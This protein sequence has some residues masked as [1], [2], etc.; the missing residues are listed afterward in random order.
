MNK[1]L[2][3]IDNIKRV[4]LNFKII[5]SNFNDL[6]FE[7]KKK[8][9]PNINLLINEFNK[10]YLKYDKSDN[11]KIK[12]QLLSYKIAKYFESE[13]YYSVAFEYYLIGIKYYY[14]KSFLSLAIYF[15]CISYNKITLELIDMFNFLIEKI[16]KLNYYQELTELKKETINLLNQIENNNMKKYSEILNNL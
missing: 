10:Y 7:S 13:K 16:K 5:E 9:E 14:P 1:L 12:L 3:K 2:L 4:K 6:K 15:Q 11:D 8:M